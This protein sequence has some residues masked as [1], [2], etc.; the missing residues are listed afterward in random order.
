M[1]FKLALATLLSYI[2]AQDINIGVFSDVHLNLAYGPTSTGKNC[3]NA[4]PGTTL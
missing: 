3:M 1:K 4:I 2:S